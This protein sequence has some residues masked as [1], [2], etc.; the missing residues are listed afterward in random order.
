VL[1]EDQF[2]FGRRKGTGDATEMLGISERSTDIDVEL[3]A[4]FIDR[5]KVFEL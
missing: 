5:Q 3:C 4:C 1:G 2:G